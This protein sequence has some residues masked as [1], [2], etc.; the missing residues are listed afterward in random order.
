MTLETHKRLS[1]RTKGR[2]VAERLTAKLNALLSFPQSQG[3][4]GEILYR[5]AALSAGIFDARNCSI[6][7]F[8]E[9]L[10]KSNLQSAPSFGDLVSV[11]R[12]GP[13]GNDPGIACSVKAS[14]GLLSTEDEKVRHIDDGCKR[15]MVCPI[16]IHGKT[17]GIIHASKPK[18]ERCFNVSDLGF[19]EVVALSIAKLSQVIRLQY[20]LNSRVAQVAPA[21]SVDSA[22]APRPALQSPPR[23]LGSGHG[24]LWTHGH[25]PLRCLEEGIAP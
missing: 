24:F 2:S 3:S 20:I 8:S 6:L 13:F 11:A 15:S 25:V 23:W 16:L 4:L 10:E 7:L 22:T 18:P 12:N 17:I 19:L 1:E 9:E 21:Q 5:L 14:E